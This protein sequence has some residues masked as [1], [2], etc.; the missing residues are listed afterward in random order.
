VPPRSKPARVLLVDETHQLTTN[1]R[2]L[3]DSQ[4]LK[5]VG[6]GCSYSSMLG[7]IIRHAPNV[8]VVELTRDNEEA[9]AAIETVMNEHPTPILVLRSREATSLDPFRALALG[10]LDVAERPR[11]PSPSFWHELAPKLVLLSQVQVVRHMKG[12]RIKRRALAGSEPLPSSPL[13]AIAASLGGPRAL[14][15]LL[16][17]MPKAFSAPICVCQHI[18]HGFT[19]GLAQ[20]LS[21]ETELRVVEA[22]D[23]E[24]LA[25]GTVFLAPSRAHLLV[26]A[27][28]R[29]KLDDGPARMGF[30]PSCDA[31]LI[32]AAESYRDKAIGIVLTGMGRDGAQ[33]LKHIR[34][35]GGHTI[36]QDR[37][38]CVVFGMPKEAVEIGAA[39]QILSLDRIA[40]AL[41]QLVERC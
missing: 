5:M 12:N 30:K 41:I 7:S 40:P 16:R 24:P 11:E 9:F 26:T 34:L 15:I 32:S 14:S 21:S 8:V 1:A 17:M 18:S 22:I 28:G 3:F 39:E 10:A 23:D 4:E 2:A 6:E 38:S 36:V 25:P 20:W 35:R 27:N 31:L 19:N 13:V 37:A 33:G 29:T